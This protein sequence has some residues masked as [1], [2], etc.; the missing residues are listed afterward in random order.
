VFKGRHQSFGGGAKSVDNLILA[1]GK[2]SQAL[3][4]EYQFVIQPDFE[5][6]SPA[7]DEGRG[8]FK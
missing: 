8:G 1:V 4:T 3:L 2:T 7:F 5:N 6:S